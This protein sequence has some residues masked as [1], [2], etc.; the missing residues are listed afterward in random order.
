MQR[1]RGDADGLAREQ[2]GGRRIEGE[3]GSTELPRSRLPP[4]VISTASD[5]RFPWTRASTLARPGATPCTVPSRDDPGDGRV[6]APEGEL[7]RGDEVALAVVGR[8][9]DRL[10]LA[11]AER[12]GLGRDLDFGGALGRGSGGRP[13]GR[14]PARQGRRRA[15]PDDGSQGD[16]LRVGEVSPAIVSRE[17]GSAAANDSLRRARSHRGS[18]R[19]T[20]A[21]AATS[22]FAP[23]R[24]AVGVGQSLKSAYSNGLQVVESAGRAS[25]PRRGRPIGTRGSKLGRR[26]ARF[27]PCRRLEDVQV[28]SHQRRFMRS[29]EL[30][31]ARVT[32]AAGHAASRSE[33]AMMAELHY[34]EMGW[35]GSGWMDPLPI[36]YPPTPAPAAPAAPTP[37][38][39][40]P[41]A[42]RTTGSSMPAATP[43]KPAR[44]AGKKAGEEGREE[45]RQGIAKKAAKK[46]PR[47]AARR[48]PRRPPARRRGGRPRNRPRRPRRRAA[49][50]PLSG[51]RRRP[52]AG[53]PSG[54][55]GRPSAAGG[56]EAIY[57]FAP[58]RA[59]AA[60]QLISAMWVK[61]CGKLPRN[62]PV[63]GSISS[64]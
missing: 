45:G 21:G 11:D 43:R 13:R 59:S 15:V 17:R 36:E 56:A 57:P 32:P 64:E 31:R 28:I 8:G 1:Q 9:E 33:G 46:S 50:R 23:G 27:E 19:A 55:R 49:G 14:M 12:H 2:H 4:P 44:K 60:A 40:S 6:R 62:S 63:T 48:P 35:S 52:R 20:T 22:A 54:R 39:P 10:A 7:G 24:L 3:N 38:S 30:L 18:T 41:S 61:A 29:G 58:V 5:A 51:V 37:A 25:R 47:R 53:P 34:M 16:P 26:A 42:A